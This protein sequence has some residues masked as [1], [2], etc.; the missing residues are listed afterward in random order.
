MLFKTGSGFRVVQS[1]LIEFVFAK[2][3]FRYGHQYANSQDDSD[4]AK[5]ESENSEFD[6]TVTTVTSTVLVSQAFVIDRL[7]F[8]TSFDL[9]L[10][11][12]IFA[13]QCVNC[14][15][16][17]SLYSSQIDDLVFQFRDLRLGNL[18]V[19][20]FKSRTTTG[21]I[22]QKLRVF[23]ELL[24][25][26][27]IAFV[28][29]GVNEYGR[30]VNVNLEGV[31]KECVQLRRPALFRNLGIGF[32]TKPHRLVMIIPMGCF[33]NYVVPKAITEHFLYQSNHCPK[34]ESCQIIENQGKIATLV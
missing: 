34:I 1:V 33:E 25:F 12:R 21:E 11:L 15:I 32:L 26:L 6:G 17:V 3:T 18:N 30:D 2:L 29:V 19:F 5:S 24:I 20:A 13:S 31:S 10:Q 28:V 16:V 23:L 14:V 7:A 4:G 22:K 8:P 27:R 9:V